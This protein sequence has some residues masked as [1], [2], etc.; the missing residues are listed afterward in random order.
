MCDGDENW[1]LEVQ[2]RDERLRR[3]RELLD[4]GADLLPWFIVGFLLAAF[5]LEML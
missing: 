1:W 3:R 2:A 5:F 4:R